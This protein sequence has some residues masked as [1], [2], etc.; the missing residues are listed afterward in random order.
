MTQ[1]KRKSK[2]QHK[3]KFQ[4]V[5]HVNL[6]EWFPARS[7]TWVSGMHRPHHLHVSSWPHTVSSVSFHQQNSFGHGTLCIVGVCSGRECCVQ[8]TTTGCPSRDWDSTG[9]QDTP[10]RYQMGR[11]DA[12]WRLVEDGCTFR[13]DCKNRSSKPPPPPPSWAQM[14]F[15]SALPSQ[16]SQGQEKAIYLNTHNSST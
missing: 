4:Y 13:G 2:H 16:G 14:K 9:R 1:T 8:V 10:K 12:I 11:L 3:C 15:P 7:G 5:Q 6:P